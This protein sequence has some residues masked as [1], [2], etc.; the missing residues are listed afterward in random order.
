MIVGGLLTQ[1]DQ[2]H[3]RAHVGACTPARSQPQHSQAVGAAHCGWDGFSPSRA[4]AGLALELC[5]GGPWD[6]DCL[7]RGFEGPRKRMAGSRL[8]ERSGREGP[9]FPRYDV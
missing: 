2:A 4:S 5:L 3:A 7:G 9:L 8:K 6:I 1:T